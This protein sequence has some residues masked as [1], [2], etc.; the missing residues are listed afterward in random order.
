MNSMGKSFEMRVMVGTYVGARKFIVKCLMTHGFRK[1]FH[2]DS[3]ERREIV[4]G[5]GR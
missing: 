4:K 2:P 3:H 1:E 5:D